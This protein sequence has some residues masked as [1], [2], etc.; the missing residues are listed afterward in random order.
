M[1]G[2]GLGVRGKLFVG[3]LLIIGVF[4]SVSGFYLERELERLLEVRIEVEL[5]RH[6]RAT[7][8]QVAVATGA[9]LAVMDAI[10]DRNGRATDSRITVIAPDGRVVGD[11]ELS[12]E[13]V[14]SVENH[15]ARPE[16]LR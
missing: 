2:S 11:S 8:E 9:D 4:G 5:V 14:K 7:A 3:S 13:A 1:K 16:V 6:A 10:A 12:L 15:G